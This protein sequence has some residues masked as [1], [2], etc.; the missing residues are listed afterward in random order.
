[1]SFLNIKGI[2][3]LSVLWMETVFKG[4]I[5]KFLLKEQGHFNNWCPCL[6]GPGRPVLGVPTPDKNHGKIPVP[7]RPACGNVYLRQE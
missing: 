1:M 2:N 6:G 7:E 4:A 5:K 3:P